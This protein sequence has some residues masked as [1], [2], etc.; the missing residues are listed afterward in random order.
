VNA[1]A[2]SL[3]VNTAFFIVG[4]LTLNSRPLERIQAG[5]F[6]KRHSRSQLTSGSE[7]AAVNNVVPG[8]MK[9]STAL[10]T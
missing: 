2:M 5:I 4:S 9:P 8:K 7:S 3:L 6:V 1:T 10:A